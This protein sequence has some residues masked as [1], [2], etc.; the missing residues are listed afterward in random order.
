MEM[1]PTPPADDFSSEDTLP[2]QSSDSEFN[3][4]SKDVQ[5]IDS[6]G[7]SKVVPFDLPS[8]LVNTLGQYLPQQ[9]LPDQ[10]Q[11]NLAPVGH[12][13]SDSNPSDQTQTIEQTL[14]QA[15]KP[16]V[17]E[18]PPSPEEPEEPKSSGSRCFLCN[19]R[20]DL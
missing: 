20:H 15:S 11:G 7:S 17:A 4:D 1:A 19:Q 14:Y 18:Q 9:A 16:T 3:N 5:G 10:V 2:P 8:Q 13:L 6:T 12:A